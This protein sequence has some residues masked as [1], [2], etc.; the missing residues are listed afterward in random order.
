MNMNWLDVTALALV[1]IGALNW[2]LVG[3]FEYNLVDA[4]FGEGSMASRIVYVLVGFAGL[5]AAF[6]LVK[7][8]QASRP[9]ASR[10]SV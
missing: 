1:V 6:T 10:P 3:A 2:G 9:Q 8:V 5:V 7:A 4:L